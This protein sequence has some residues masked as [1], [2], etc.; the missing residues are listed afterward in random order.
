MIS[1][2]RR[3]QSDLLGLEKSVSKLQK[4]VRDWE[5]K[6]SVR[7]TVATTNSEFN[8]SVKNTSVKNTSVKNLD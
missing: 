6:T 3:A 5:C 7:V 8:I 4:V 1:R 2:V